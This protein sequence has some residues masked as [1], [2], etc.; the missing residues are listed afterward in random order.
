MGKISQFFSDWLNMLMGKPR[1]SLKTLQDVKS[2]NANPDD[3]NN[4]INS[5]IAKVK[6]VS[7]KIISSVEGKIKPALNVNSKNGFDFVKFASELT[8]KVI[9]IL[10]IALVKKIVIGLLVLF[11][12]VF[13]VG[14]ISKFFL[15]SSDK[16]NGITFFEKTP[17]P[18]QTDFRPSQ[19]SIY[20]SDKTVLALE[21]KLGIFVREVDSTNLRENLLMPPELD[22]SINF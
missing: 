16:P 3:A 10:K 13:G 18:I 8:A 9:N 19:P 20:A 5:D 17:T 7:K 14:L 11:V 12:F 22:F 1:S 21:E 6:E 15:R 2:E 4:P